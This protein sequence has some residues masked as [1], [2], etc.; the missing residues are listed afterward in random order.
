MLM[1]DIVARPARLAQIAAAAFEEVMASQ[2]RPK[3]MIRR[4]TDAAREEAEAT[5]DETPAAPADEAFD[6]AFNEVSLCVRRLLDDTGHH[7]K[8]VSEIRDAAHKL[9]HQVNANGA[10]ES[11]AFVAAA[12]ELLQADG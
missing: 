5:L 3:A 4:I 7:P 1:S 2:N 6:V 10:A 9:A 12:R 11:S 8:T